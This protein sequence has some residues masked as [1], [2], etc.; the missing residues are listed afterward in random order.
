MRPA[1]IKPATFQSVAEHL[2]H[3]ATAVP[4]DVIYWGGKTY[5]AFKKKV[6]IV[7]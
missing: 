5:K 1:G 3:T 6:L 7:P 2:N 4:H